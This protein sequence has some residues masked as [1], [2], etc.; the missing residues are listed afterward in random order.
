[1]TRGL[2]FLQSKGEG[3]CISYSIEVR[4]VVFLTVYTVGEVGL[5]ILVWRVEEVCVS[6]E[7]TEVKII[8]FLTVQKRG[9]L[10]FLCIYTVRGEGGCVSYSTVQGK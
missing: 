5:C 4:G 10:C 7:C 6:S 8:V 2:C 3:G 1:V 9:G